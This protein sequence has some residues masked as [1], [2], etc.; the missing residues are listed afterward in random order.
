MRQIA[1]A[2]GVTPAAVSMA[3]ANH[4]RISIATRRRAHQVALELGYVPNP[5]VSALM[6]TRRS[7]R[8][9]NSR[10]TVALINLTPTREGWA[11]HVSSTVRQM[12]SGAI[13]QAR[14]RGY[15]I[16]E[17]W[18]HEPGMSAARLSD[19]LKARG[20][21]GVLFSP[22]PDGQQVPAMKWECFSATA[23]AVPQPDVP[24]PTVCN[25]HYSSM[26][27]ALD[28]CHR[29]GYRRPGLVHRQ[30][31]LKRLQGRWVSAFL[32]APEL[33]A[34]LQPVPA[35]RP[36]LVGEKLPE[37]GPWLKEHRPDVIV[38]PSASSVA[39][40]LRRLGCK[41]PEDIGLV[42]LSCAEHGQD[43][44]GIIQ[45]GLVIGSAALDSLVSMVERNACG[46]AD[47]ARALMIQG[48]WNPGRTLRRQRSVSV[49]QRPR[50]PRRDPAVA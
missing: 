13:D 10:P 26:L 37:L 28:H 20:I 33:L 42:S 36:E 9:E 38:T 41:C 34:G 22:F 6:R 31:M 23:L 29:L 35:L 46:L 49:P 47:H 2:L 39:E 40:E 12:R 16:E 45:N 27:H 5:Y 3:L 44:S 14:L 17:F 7:G 21:R 4:P 48:E 30:P 50:G 43:I 32:F 11:N 25:D 15:R 8:D 19:I 1:E 18:L 24:I